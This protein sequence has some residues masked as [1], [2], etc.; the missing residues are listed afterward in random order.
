MTVKARFPKGPTLFV[1]GVVLALFALGTVAIKAR[2]WRNSV[3]VTS[4]G[5]QISVAPRGLAQVVRFTVYDVGIFP[6]EARVSPGLVAL[7]IEDMSGNSNGLLVQTETGI[8]LGQ[9]LRGERQWRG[10]NRIL[11]TSG[12]YQVIDANR[13]SSRA[14]LIVEP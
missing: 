1:L 10:S 9:V 2:A 12:R 3:R 5:P 6:A 13:R 8:L 11:L 7:H 14:T 4:S